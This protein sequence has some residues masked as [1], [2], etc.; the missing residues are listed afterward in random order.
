G[1]IYAATGR[2]GIIYQIDGGKVTEFCVL[3][4]GGT[5]LSLLFAKDGKLL[6][7]TGGRD[8][9]KIY[10]IDGTGKA[11]VFCELPEATY[12]W[13]MVRG[14]GG[15]VYAATGIEGQLYKISPDGSKAEA[16]AD[17]KPKNLL[18]LAMGPNGML[19][20]GTDEDG[21]VYRIAPA[22]GGSFVMYDAPQ[23]EIS[24]IVIDAVGNVYASTADADAAKPGREIADKPGGKP[25][26][27]DRA[28]GPAPKITVATREG[29]EA[30]TKPADDKG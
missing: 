9:A 13:A 16:L 24:A 14:S 12:V 25:E 5:I 29:E 19:Y 7:G 22:D 4:E 2:G 15:E 20:A 11:T 1:K 17:L 18:C 3:E 6:A 10:R 28:T 27:D 26:G 8:Q 23:P 30:E 21:L